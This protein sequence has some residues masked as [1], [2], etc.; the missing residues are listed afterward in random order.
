MLLVFTSVTYGHNCIKKICDF[1]YR[2]ECTI[3]KL[4]SN[5]VY[6]CLQILYFG[7][8]I[9]CSNGRWCC[10]H[11][12]FTALKQWYK[13]HISMAGTSLLYHIQVQLHYLY[14]SSAVETWSI[15][16]HISTKCLKILNSLFQMNCKNNLDRQ[17]VS[18]KGEK[19]RLSLINYC[20]YT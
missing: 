17:F 2:L 7:V 12:P 14:I 3:H 15:W 6:T 20:K 5:I 8:F 1:S 4:Q 19:Y 18:L 10:A 13:L 9:S 16:C 11:L